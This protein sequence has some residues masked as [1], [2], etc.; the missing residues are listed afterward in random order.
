MEGLIQAIAETPFQSG[1]VVGSA[2]SVCARCGRPLTDPISIE[3]GLG[4]V[5]FGRC[6]VDASYFNPSQLTL[7]PLDASEAQVR[8]D[9]PGLTFYHI[10]EVSL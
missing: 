8:Q 9:S 1:G 3:R 7:F 2:V 4:P 6:Q 5:C 10:E